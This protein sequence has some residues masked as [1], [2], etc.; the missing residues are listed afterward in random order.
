[1]TARTVRR[2]LIAAAAGGVFA[3][4]A[5]GAQAAMIVYDPASYAKLIEQAR[6]ALGQLEAL[7]TQVSQGQQLLGSLNDASGLDAL[8]RELD[9]PAL[10][11]VLPDATALASGAG[12]FEALGDIGRRAD[13]IRQAERLYTPAPEDAR[14]RDLDGA[15]NRAARDLALGEAVMDA[16]ADRLEGLQTLQG[17]IGQAATARGVFDL[18]AR[19][20]AE[21]AMIANDQVRLQG[22]AMAQDAEDRLQVQRERERAAASRKARMDLYRQ[23][24]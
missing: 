12:G 2:H 19:L 7:K 6:T 11:N 21:Q 8:A 24:F 3:A 5:A 4:A 23:G 22:L 18:Q 9:Q 13:V 1:M 15:G 14:G 17:A 10:R 16:G 20:A